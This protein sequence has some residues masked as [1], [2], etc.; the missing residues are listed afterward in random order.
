MDFAALGQT[1]NA[2]I[3]EGR[4]E[5]AA[6]ICRTILA[7]DPS[8]RAARWTLGTL[9]IAAGD[10]AEGWALYEA[11]RELPETQILSP[12]TSSPEWDGSAVR[13]LLVWGEQGHGDQIMF[14]RYIPPLVARGIDVTLA[15]RPAL[16]R[17]FS[18][19]GARVVPM[20][21]TVSTPRSDAWCLMGSLPRHFPEIPSAP[22]LPSPARGRGI[23]VMATGEA[24][25]P[26]DARRSLFGPAAEDLLRLG[27]DLSPQ[28]TGARDFQDTADIIA[29]LDLVISVDTA[30]AHLAGAM[31]KACWV[32][33][34]YPSEWRWGRSGE[35]TPWYSS[36]R[37]F[38]A[39][40]GEALDA[41]VDRVRGAL[42]S[43]ASG[44]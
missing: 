25:H 8:H 19:L 43:P 23:G 40:P 7:V 35:T 2:L 3:R 18:N 15:C 37:L 27:R 42:N 24:S 4:D 12:P 13:R 32:L 11:R 16:V 29:S 10:F 22:Y 6:E 31:G 14:A 36:A 17:L 44:R 33:L 26:N 20:A 39:A 9:L 34:P 30:V 28:A 38:R 41:V 21:G 5:E 1:A